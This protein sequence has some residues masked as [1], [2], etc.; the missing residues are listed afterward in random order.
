VAWN[1]NKSQVLRRANQVSIG[2]QVHVTLAEGE[3]QCEVRKRGSP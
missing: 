1:E 3:L 2:D